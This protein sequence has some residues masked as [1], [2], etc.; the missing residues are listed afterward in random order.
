MISMLHMTA[1]VWYLNDASG[2]C[3]SKNLDSSLFTK[4][5]L[6]FILVL[7]N[8]NNVQQY[9]RSPTEDFH[10]RYQLTRSAAYSVN[11]HTLKCSNRVVVGHV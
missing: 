11:A 2:E 5:S 8:N 6:D 4:F 1:M 7:K 3:C 10:I 9:Q